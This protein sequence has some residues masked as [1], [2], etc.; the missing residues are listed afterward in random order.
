MV[1]RIFRFANCCSYTTDTSV[2]VPMV[3]FELHTNAVRGKFITL[4]FTPICN[5]RFLLTRVCSIDL[6]EI[7]ARARASACMCRD[8]N[9]DKRLDMKVFAVNRIDNSTELQKQE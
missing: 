4:K 8:A 2:S 3:S 9:C 7:R 5:I 6:P 1:K